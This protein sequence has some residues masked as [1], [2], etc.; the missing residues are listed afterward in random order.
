MITDQ[1]FNKLKLVRNLRKSEKKFVDVYCI[2]AM[3]L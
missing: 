2:L 3:E 1:G